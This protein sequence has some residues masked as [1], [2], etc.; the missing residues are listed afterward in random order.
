MG[1]R[2]PP[3]RQQGGGDGQA[4]GS[5]SGAIRGPGP[6]WNAMVGRPWSPSAPRRGSAVYRAHAAGLHII[7][8]GVKPQ[9]TMPGIDCETRFRKQPL[10]AVKLF[11]QLQQAT[12]SS[13][14]MQHFHRHTSMLRPLPL[15]PRARM[16]KPAMEKR[17]RERINVALEELKRLVAEPFLKEN[18]QKL[19]KADILDLTVKFVLDC[20]TRAKKLSNQSSNWTQNAPWISFM[21]GYTACEAV[22]RG[23]FQTQRQLADDCLSRLPSTE[24][25][26]LLLCLLDK[27]RQP[28]AGNFLRSLDP[29]FCLLSPLASLRVPDYTSPTCRLLADQCRRL[30]TV[31]LSASFASSAVVEA[32]HS[33]ESSPR[34]S[35]ET[36]PSLSLSSPAVQCFAHSGQQPGVNSD[37]AVNLL[38]DHHILIGWTG[39]S[40]LPDGIV[41]DFLSALVNNFPRLVAGSSSGSFPLLYPVIEPSHDNAL[42]S[43]LPCPY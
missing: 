42:F 4:I 19:E 6:L 10:P 34:Q 9:F 21:A 41:P 27:Q 12:R 30:D 17:R 32:P 38:V 15:H 36:S 1:V 25:L 39:L 3:T 8:S 16:R 37:A 22:L 13:G 14:R 43:R 7:M 2:T 23:L 29:S 24:L 28:A 35:P 11:P 26:P 18:A 40:L 33:P 31:S 5:A 20:I